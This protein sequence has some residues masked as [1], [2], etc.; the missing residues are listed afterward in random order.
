MSNA[1]TIRND[2]D[3]MSLGEVLVRSRFFQDSTDAAQAIVKVL[4][5]RELGFGPIASMTGVNI[6]KGRVTL[7]ANLMAAAIKRTGKYNYRVAEHT[8]QVCELH[9]FEGGELVGVSRFTMDDA[10]TAGLTENTTW[11]KFPRN[12]LFSRAIS[13]GAKWYCP[14]IFGGP[15]YTP[16]ELG[17]DVDEDGNI[18]EAKPRPVPALDLP[19][20]ADEPEGAPEP[21]PD[22]PPPWAWVERDD[23]WNALVKKAMTD[24]WPG[25][26]IPHARN[27]VAKALLLPGWDARHT[28]RGDEKTAWAL[29]SAYRSGD[30]V[31]PGAEP[32]SPAH[33]AESDVPRK[34]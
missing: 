30:D 26:T 25:L 8:D 15:V 2:I 20:P 6:I 7:S 4:A 22:A 9:F 14:D 12:M 28:Y 33:V 13:N 1:L 32:E 19:A 3:I 17:E 5:G 34:K 31:Q 29:V 16:D 27:R 11:R 10:R 21:P 24:L 18:I 23:R